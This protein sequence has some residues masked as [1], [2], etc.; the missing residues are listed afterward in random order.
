[1]IV[2]LDLCV[3]LKKPRLA[4]D[5]LHQ[6]RVICQQTN[7]SSMA[8]VMKHFLETSEK[9][10]EAAQNEAEQALLK[11]GDRVKSAESIEAKLLNSVSGEDAKDRAD[12]EHVTPWLKFLWETYKTV[13]DILRTNQKLESLY[14]HTARH[15]FHFC[16][17]YERKTEFRR[18]SEILRIHFSNIT[19]YP[20]QL[21]ALVQSEDSLP[22][23]LQTAF[24]QLN[25]AAQLELWQEAFRVIEGIR[26]I[27]VLSR[28]PPKP[29]MM[30]AYYEKLTQVF[31]VANNHLYHGFCAYKHLLISLTHNKGM[32]AE[33][34][35]A[36]ANK[37]SLAILSIPMKKEQSKHVDKRFEM[38]VQQEKDLK[39]AALLGLSVAPTRT[40]LIKELKD[41]RIIDDA[42]P[43]TREL[44][45]LLEH[46]FQPLE[47][48]QSIRAPL[49]RVRADPSNERYLPPLERLVT[50]K[51]L[52]Q[53]ESVYENMRLQDLKQLTSFVSA[54]SPEKL[55]VQAVRN[56]Y[57]DARID[58]QN[59][60]VHFGSQSLES[61]SLR[62]HLTHFATAIQSATKMLNPEKQHQEQQKAAHEQYSKLAARVN[63]EHKALLARR[64]VVEKKK[65]MLEIREKH[66]IDREELAK[67]EKAR[68][69]RAREIA[70]LKHLEEARAADAKEE[71]R[72]ALLEKQKATIVESIKNNKQLEQE[73]VEQLTQKIEEDAIDPRSLLG[74]QVRIMNERQADL[75]AKMDK[76][77][78]RLDHIERAR[79]KAEKP[80]L[81]SAILAENQTYQQSMSEY[82]DEQL[83]KHKEAWLAAK[84]E[85]VRLATVLSVRSAFEARLTSK[86][87][88]TFEATKT[89]QDARLAPQREEIKAKRAQEAAKLDQE[90]I[91]ALEGAKRKARE[92]KE[93]AKTSTGIDFVPPPSRFAATA[94]AKKPATATPATP[95]AAAAAAGGGSRWGDS[96]DATTQ[97]FRPNKPE[98]AASPAAGG[99]KKEAYRPPVARAATG[100]AGGDRP[101]PAAGD[102]D[103]FRP[104]GGDRPAERGDRERDTFRPGGGDRPERSERDTFRPGGGDRPA[105]RGG[106]REREPYRPSGGDRPEREGDRERDT[107]RPGG[108]DRPERS[109][110]DRGAERDSGSRWGD[111]D[112][113]REEGARDVYRPREGGR[114]DS[115]RP[116]G[117]DRDRD[118]D[119]A[120]GRSDVY[121]PGGGDRDRAGGRGGDDKGREE[122][123]RP[124]GAGSTGSPSSA[125]RGGWSTAGKK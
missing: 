96:P 53:L 59:G 75:R 72:K 81:E 51:V 124:P 3:D 118:R 121:R 26:L 4:K 5:G 22:L 103:T 71:Q 114:G 34:R 15:A 92:E 7:L 101:R 9:A 87:Q 55:I 54:S 38:D 18:L 13:L 94:A 44:Y 30:A 70:H 41:R 108:G 83:T 68:D 6:Y 17:K 39:L 2:F 61:D 69:Q 19:R 47:L 62:D 20:Q 64:H 66:R 105:E 58:H 115:Y 63:E 123:Y 1:M 74:A 90:R 110:G 23:R 113:G 28:R 97:V 95:P 100:A 98:S 33:E 111:R 109:G 102:R 67:I 107:F 120:G 42:R 11:S 65:E 36:Q 25:T 80:K 116:G 43:E 79:R 24:A 86:R 35:S 21:E 49:D 125:G 46:R 91:V 27:L 8:F 76:L 89:E 32:S 88:R 56:H 122:R 93:K 48:C 99:D 12:R 117:G 77:A 73:V 85:K 82:R 119:S 57:V 60:V 50:A 29:Q 14:H 84:A 78:V 112:R 106:D 16:I 45:E 52:K 37:V 10:A 31:W 40:F 104:G